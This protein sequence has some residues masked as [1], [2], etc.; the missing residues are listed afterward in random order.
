MT[1]VQV[2]PTSPSYQHVVYINI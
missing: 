2:F 1:N